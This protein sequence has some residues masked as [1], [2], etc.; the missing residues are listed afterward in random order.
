MRENL[1]TRKYRLGLDARKFSCAKISTFTVIYY[2]SGRATY[3]CMYNMTDMFICTQNP[4][5][6]I[7]PIEIEGAQKMCRIL[8]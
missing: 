2:S 1:S 7:N 3:N 6:R 4:V 5:A 8:V